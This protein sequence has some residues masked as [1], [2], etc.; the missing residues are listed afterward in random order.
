MLTGR[1]CSCAHW[2]T[3]L[4]TLLYKQVSSCSELCWTTPV[5]S[6]VS[7][8]PNHM[9]TPWP[10]AVQCVTRCGHCVF[11]EMIMLLWHHYSTFWFNITDVLISRINL[12]MGWQREKWSEDK[13]NKM[14]LYK[15]RSRKERVLRLNQSWTQTSSLWYCGEISSF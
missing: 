9:L 5:G 7:Y 6:D 4:V 13:G 2:A 11:T 1:L 3:W 14:I 10:H 15:P 8:P 12:E